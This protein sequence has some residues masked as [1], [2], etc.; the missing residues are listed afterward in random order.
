VR[1]SGQR[2]EAGIR[3]RLALGL[4]VAAAPA[5]QPA[6]EP[7]QPGCP[8]KRDLTWLKDYRVVAL[9]IAS[10]VGGFLLAVVLFIQPWHLKPA[11]GDLATWM[12]AVVGAVAAGFVL[13]Q[14]RQQQKA[15]EE[16]RIRGRKR[17]LGADH[18]LAEEVGRVIAGPAATP[19]TPTALP[20]APASI[21][22]LLG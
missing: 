1:G 6:G 2:R 9:S 21:T 16:D 5:G 17:G 10:A 18:D 12:T 19:A 14:L 13:A 22:G 15:I 4:P 20:P 7:G 3:V 8:R 11:I